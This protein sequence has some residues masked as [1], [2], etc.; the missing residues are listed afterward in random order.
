MRGGYVG[1][2]HSA[3]AKY[4]DYSIVKKKSILVRKLVFSQRA[5]VSPTGNETRSWSMRLVYGQWDSPTSTPNVFHSKIATRLRTMGN[6]HSMRLVYGQWDALMEHASRLRT[7]GLAQKVFE[8]RLR[9]MRLI[10]TR[11]KTCCFSDQF[12]SCYFATTYSTR[13][14]LT[15]SI[16]DS[17]RSFFQRT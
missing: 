12:I 10:C 16:F 15:S 5:C 14:T 8:T 13:T 9:T 17:I 1:V 11:N 6:F 2:I 4:T 3:R 7:M